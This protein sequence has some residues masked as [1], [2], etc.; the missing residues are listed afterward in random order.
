MIAGLDPLDFLAHQ[1][2]TA[3]L[4]GGVG[5]LWLCL[6]EDLRTKWRREAEDLFNGWRQHELEKQASR[7]EID[8]EIDRRF[9]VGGK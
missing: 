8:D 1:L 9:P 6:R 5:P 7:S 2:Y 3:S 4:N